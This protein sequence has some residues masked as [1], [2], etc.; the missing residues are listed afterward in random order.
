MN[1]IRLR[2]KHRQPKNTLT[3]GEADVVDKLGVVVVSEAVALVS[4]DLLTSPERK[5]RF[6]PIAASSCAPCSSSCSCSL[7]VST[8][9]SFFTI[10]FF[11]VVVVLD[12]GGKH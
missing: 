6:L 8:S 1:Q 5:D 2:L 7:S 11:S 9:S 3:V 12:H 10:T 4:S